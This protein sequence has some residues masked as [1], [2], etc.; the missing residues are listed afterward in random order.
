MVLSM[1]SDTFSKI[2]EHELP[3][4][5]CSAFAGHQKFE[6]AESESKARKRKRDPKTVEMRFSNEP[7]ILLKIRMPLIMAFDQMKQNRCCQKYQ[8]S[9]KL[10][11]R[12]FKFWS[13]LIIS[14]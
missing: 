3:R 12:P 8:F 7:E 11:E 5:V 6:R 10:S 4:L 13:E 14:Y 2:Q 1:R 9:T